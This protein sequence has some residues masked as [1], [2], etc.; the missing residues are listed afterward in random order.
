[1]ECF[2]YTRDVVD[3]KTSPRYCFHLDPWQDGYSAT[4]YPPNVDGRENVT[5]FT[6]K[7]IIGCISYILMCLNH[8]DCR[9]LA[10][11]ELMQW[12]CHICC[13]CDYVALLPLYGEV[14]Y[15]L[16]E[17]SERIYVECKNA[18]SGVNKKS[19]TLLAGNH[20]NNSKRVK[21]E[22]LLSTAKCLNGLV[23]NLT[24][25]LGTSMHLYLRPILELISHYTEYA[26]NY[27]NGGI[28]DT[29]RT[30]F[31]ILSILPHL[32]STA[33]HL[34]ASHPE[35]SVP[36]LSE[37]GHNLLRLAKKNYLKSFSNDALRDALTEYMGAHL[38]IAE[39]AGK[40]YGLPEGDLGPL[41]SMDEEEEE[42]G[43]DGETRK[44]GAT[45]DKRGIDSLLDIV[46]DAK[47]WESLFASEKQDTKKIY[48]RNRFR[49][50]SKK[51]KKHTLSSVEGGGKWTPLNKRQRRYLELLARLLRISQRLHLA[52]AE[53]VGDGT[54]D[55]IE[56]LKNEAEK[57]MQRRLDVENGEIDVSVGGDSD[58]IQQ[59]ALDDAL[60]ETPFVVLVCRH[61]YQLNPKLNDAVVPEVAKESSITQS[62]MFTQGL[63]FEKSPSGHDEDMESHQ[64]CLLQS[65]HLLR[66]LVTKQSLNKDKI[67]S[68]SA[69]TETILQL[70][71]ACAES[72][73]RGECWSSSSRQNWS[74]TLDEDTYNGGA[75]ARV[76]ER[77]GSSVADAAT[78]VYL[79]GTTLESCGG[80][81]GDEKIQVWT[82]MA[83]LKMTESSAIIS[84]RDGVSILS[85]EA[86]RVSWQFVW[87]TLFRYDLRYSSFTSGAYGSNAG[88]LVLQLITQII[89]YQCIDRR[90]ERQPL[91]SICAPFLQS[92]ILDILRLPVLQK[93]ASI[94]SGTCFELVTALIQFAE[95][96]T[97]TTFSMA[98]FD[99][100]NTP[101]ENRDRR[102]LIS[103]CLQFVES[104]LVKNTAESAIQRSYHPFVATC[105]ASLISDGNIVQNTSSFELDN[106]K[107]FS[108]TEDADPVCIVNRPDL[109]PLISNASL[110]QVHDMLWRKTMIPHIQPV[111]S[112]LRLEQRVAQGRGG[113][114]N[115]FSGSIREREKLFAALRVTSSSMY[116]ARKHDVLGATSFDKIKPIFDEILFGLRYGSDDEDE[117]EGEHDIAKRNKVTDTPRLT[118]CL[119][120][121]LT[122]VL[123]SRATINDVSKY[124]S[125]IAPG[126]IVRV[127]DHLPE[128]FD[129]MVLNP[130]DL[131]SILNHL[132]GICRVLTYCKAVNG[133]NPIISS[134]RDQFK[135]ILTACRGMLKNHRHK[136]YTSSYVSPSHKLQQQIDFRQGDES[137]N[138]RFG[139][140]QKPILRRSQNTQFSDDS[141]GFMDDAEDIGPSRLG[142]RPPPKRSAP[143]PKRQRSE[144]ILTQVKEDRTTVDAKTIDCQCA[145]SCASLMILLNPSIECLEIITGHLVWPEDT[146]TEN[147]YSPV[148]KPLDPIEAV[149]CSSLFIRR[150]VILRE[151][152]LRSSSSAHQQDNQQS[153]IVLCADVIL[154]AR[155]H[156]SPSS[157]YFMHGLGLLLKLVE[158][159]DRSE[160]FPFTSQLE[161]KFLVDT[162]YP[163][164]IGQDHEDYRSMRQLRKVLR[165]RKFYLAEQ[166]HVCIGLFLSGQDNVHAALDSIFSEHFIKVSKFRM[167]CRALFVTGQLKFLV[168][169]PRS[170]AQNSH[171]FAKLTGL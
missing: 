93:P 38:L 167:N 13:R 116:V 112:C 105:L 3:W 109:D 90:V 5:I 146:D 33:T 124:I 30:E 19:K 47:V 35:Q 164:G 92:K 161:S 158:I 77:H 71:C 44:L 118:G 103:V 45:L 48:Q 34:L 111:D 121:L 171:R 104:S 156:L 51:T 160:G 8:E 159:G 62:T 41:L 169:L 128:V 20:H 119:S 18:S 2:G 135:A 132:D 165:F 66:A 154:E 28:D 96:P 117:S 87:K 127:L 123:S 155:R 11:A 147:G 69:S 125:D 12:L 40:L 63:P 145:W 64:Q 25:R 136:T 142:R 24:T 55:P 56:E 36:V 67:D 31:D 79:L 114:L 61:L 138:D 23:Y 1:M 9:L 83:L 143:P 57:M 4:F 73:P 84:T 152:I 72:F 70:V 86:L 16:N 81:G 149:V 75:S 6:S 163:E 134:L 68:N 141:D 150:S 74:T 110:S 43:D 49:T 98:I 97:N 39:V 15:V 133:E 131:L 137:D 139:S 122:I 101:P 91:G 102:W 148:S 130:A 54:T 76:R 17:I 65:C 106:L 113:I 21:Q 129:A 126:T 50:T 162:M 89:R 46:R 37:C 120:I 22:C 80:S 88:E 94:L 153:A 99:V 108:V 7:E 27:Q 115:Q 170:S 82:L 53:A 95:V 100:S 14:S 59:L 58:D 166:L 168:C 107:K 140:A 78:V 29:D 144:K 60:A 26:W 157:K 85:L 10:E 32:Y 52:E 151:H 42:K